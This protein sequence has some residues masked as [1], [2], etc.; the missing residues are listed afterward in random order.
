VNIPCARPR[1]VSARR[2]RIGYFEEIVPK[3]EPRGDESE[4][5]ELIPGSGIVIRR[6]DF[7]D[8]PKCFP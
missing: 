8:C 1:E 7:A 6:F 3:S 4:C 2:I 5:A